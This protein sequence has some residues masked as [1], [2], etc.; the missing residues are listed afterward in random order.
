MTLKQCPLFAFLL[1]LISAPC[2][3]FPR[4]STTDKEDWAAE[5]LVA[6]A[7][8]PIIRGPR[9]QGTLPSGSGEEVL[10]ARYELARRVEERSLSEEELKGLLMGQDVEVIDCVQ[11]GE[12]C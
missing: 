11:C 5:D 1:I 7:L 9:S 12:L 4:S 2:S 6:M 10:G 3:P 8:D